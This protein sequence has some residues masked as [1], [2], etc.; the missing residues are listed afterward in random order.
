MAKAE[1]DVHWSERETSGRLPWTLN[2]STASSSEWIIDADGGCL[3]FVCFVHDR[4]RDAFLKQ[5]A[6]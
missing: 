2:S 1:E 5:M 4:D 3:G 6:K